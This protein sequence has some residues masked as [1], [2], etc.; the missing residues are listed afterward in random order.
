M[1]P[2]VGATALERP[3]FLW[4]VVDLFLKVRVPPEFLWPTDLVCR[5]LWRVVKVKVR[6]V[7]PV[8]FLV[9][10]VVGPVRIIPVVNSVPVWVNPVD[11]RR[12]LVSGV[13]G[14][15]VVVT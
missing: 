6:V 5:V 13:Q 2:A 11:V 3:E 12:V 9:V 15:R 14:Q 7:N 4:R 10:L 1:L 8:I